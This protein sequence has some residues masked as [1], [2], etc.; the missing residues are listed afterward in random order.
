MNK[1]KYYLYIPAEKS[2]YPFTKP[3]VLS[4]SGLILATHFFMIRK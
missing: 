2:L 3:D 4:I 1:R